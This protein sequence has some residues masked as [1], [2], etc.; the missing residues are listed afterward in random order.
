MRAARADMIS[1]SARYGAYNSKIL[2]GFALLIIA[3]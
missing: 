2:A 1:V 3:Q